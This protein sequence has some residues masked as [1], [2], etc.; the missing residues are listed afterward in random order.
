[1]WVDWGGAV[2]PLR[3]WDVSIENRTRTEVN[4]NSQAR[5]DSLIR[6]CVFAP[7]R[8]RDARSGVGSFGAA[9]SGR[10][11]LPLSSTAG[12]KALWTGPQ[13]RWST[14][15]RPKLDR[16]GLKIYEETIQYHYPRLLGLS[17][18]LAG[19]R[20]PVDLEAP[21][22]NGGHGISNDALCLSTK[23]LLCRSSSVR[24]STI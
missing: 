13:G 11:A 19:S 6:E 4:L 17:A 15:G 22:H 10:P 12:G 2:M 23:Q 7:S 21:S 24:V 20:S 3:G 5:E 9:R 18:R 1:M 8:L 16:H 14:S